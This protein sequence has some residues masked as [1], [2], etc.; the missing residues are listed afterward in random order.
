MLFFD[1]RPYPV[2]FS[3]GGNLKFHAQSLSIFGHSRNLIL[4]GLDDS[5]VVVI[6]GIVL[7]PCGHFWNLGRGLLCAFKF[8][9]GGIGVFPEHL[10]LEFQYILR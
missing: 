6:T 7:A 4:I 1:W 10:M 3:G 8:V 2:L 9:G 5:F